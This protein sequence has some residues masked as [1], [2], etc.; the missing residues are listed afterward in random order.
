VFLP[1]RL[2]AKLK[3][4]WRCKRGDGPGHVAG[5]LRGIR[6]ARWVRAIPNADEGA[7]ARPSMPR[8]PTHSR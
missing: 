4:Y 8:E 7:S 5:S 2:V 3:R 1:D 6:G